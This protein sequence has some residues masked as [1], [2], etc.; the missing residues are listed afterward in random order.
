MGFEWRRISWRKGLNGQSGSEIFLSGGP[1]LLIS[2]RKSLK[3]CIWKHIHTE[4][5]RKIWDGEAA[6]KR[7][8]IRYQLTSRNAEEKNCRFPPGSGSVG[9]HPRIF[10][11]SHPPPLCL[12]TIQLCTQSVPST[13]S[14]LSCVDHSDCNCSSCARFLSPHLTLSS[15]SGS[16]PSYRSLLR[17][18]PGGWPPCLSSPG[19]TGRRCGI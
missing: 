18:R 11:S 9:C 13:L 2:T 10:M 8:Q 14:V 7:Q 19:P 12:A 17:R 15:P 1:A 6:L 4:L 3:K 16:D 5:Q